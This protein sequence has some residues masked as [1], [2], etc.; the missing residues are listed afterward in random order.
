MTSWTLEAHELFM[1][2]VSWSFLVIHLHR[3]SAKKSSLPTC[4]RR[5][6]KNWNCFLS[7]INC[8]CLSINVAQFR[9]KADV[10]KAELNLSPQLIISFEI[11]R[12]LATSPKPFL[13]RDLLRL[14][15]VEKTA[16]AC[17][18]SRLLIKCLGTFCNLQYFHVQLFKCEKEYLT[19]GI[20][21]KT[22]S[23]TSRAET[24]LSHR[25]ICRDCVNYPLHLRLR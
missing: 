13:F 25:S 5:V 10:N 24:F 1:I 17:V 21:W 14:V 18:N 9:H 6:I 3:D 7:F 22:P 4:H 2:H 16:L 19:V 8:R 23:K 15:R 12:N 11:H 20:P